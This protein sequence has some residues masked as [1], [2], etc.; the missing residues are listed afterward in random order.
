MNPHCSSVQRCILNIMMLPIMI[1]SFSYF[2]SM[3]L[4]VLSLFFSCLNIVQCFLGI[5]VALFESC[6][7]VFLRITGASLAVVGDS[8]HEVKLLI[9]IISGKSLVC[10]IDD[11]VPLL[12]VVG[13]NGLSIIIDEIIEPGSCR[14]PCCIDVHVHH[15]SVI[16]IGC[17]KQHLCLA[18]Q[19]HCRCECHHQHF[20]FHISSY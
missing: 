20:L 18:A 6:L 2:L 1:Q 17:R 4:F 13:I 7:Q 16:Q 9:F 8:S 19:C 11:I 3:N 14:F 15:A 10:V 5:L 12:A